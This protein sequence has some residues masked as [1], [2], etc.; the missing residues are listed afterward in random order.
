LCAEDVST[1]MKTVD[2][3]GVLTPEEAH[4]ILVSNDVNEWGEEARRSAR[5][6]SGE[7]VYY[8]RLSSPEE[9]AGD[10]YDEV[11]LSE[12]E[13]VDV[14]AVD[15]F[16]GTPDDNL[17]DHRKA[18]SNG[19]PTDIAVVYGD[20]SVV[21]RLTDVHELAPDGQMRGVTLH[22]EENEPI[23]TAYTDLKTVAVTRLFLSPE[24]VPLIRVARDEVGDK[25]AQTALEY[26]A[27]D[28]GFVGEGDENPELISR[29]IGLEP[30]ERADVF[31]GEL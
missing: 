2:T 26:G 24:D 12:M 13:N 20:G 9:V 3:D 29:E 1:A 28:L 22:P 5:E 4:E 14:N 11:P 25:L 19:V 16:I 21:E 27:N 7:R 15:A 30:V 10:G 23:T 8:G 31:G 6:A 17:E 18:H